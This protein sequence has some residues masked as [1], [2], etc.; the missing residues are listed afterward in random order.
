MLEL[1]AATRRDHRQSDQS[2][3]D[4]TVGPTLVSMCFLELAIPVERLLIRNKA[5]EAGVSIGVQTNCYSQE[6][7]LAAMLHPSR[8]RPGLVLFCVVLA[9]MSVGHHMVVQSQ[10]KKQACPAKTIDIVLEAQSAQQKQD[11]S[12]GGTFQCRTP[13]V[14]RWRSDEGKAAQ[15]PAHAIRT[16]ELPGKFGFAQNSKGLFRYKL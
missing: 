9:V 10:E 3:S 16:V 4:Q 5:V 2:E 13:V 8:R 1:Q 6:T 7:C 14:I 15:T 12:F 11:F